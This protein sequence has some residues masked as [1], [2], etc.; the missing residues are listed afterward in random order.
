MI[1]FLLKTSIAENNAV[2]ILHQSDHV[3]GAFLEH[4]QSFVFS[5]NIFPFYL[6]HS[7]NFSHA[8]NFISSVSKRHLERRINSKILTCLI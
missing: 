6:S 3:L 8:A 2:E 1:P 5:K 7:S 4:P